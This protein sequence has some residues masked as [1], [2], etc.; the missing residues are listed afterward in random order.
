[1]AY[2][3]RDCMLKDSEMMGQPNP[4]LNEVESDLEEDEDLEGSTGGKEEFL[5]EVA[6]TIKRCI[7]HKFPLDNA[8][9]EIKS[10][11]MSENLTYSDCVDGIAPPILHLILDSYKEGDSLK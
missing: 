3:P 9:L 1:M 11:K 4:Y 7:T 8:A 6:R 10:L 2:L 5:R